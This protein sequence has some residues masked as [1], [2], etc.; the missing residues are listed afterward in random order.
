MAD[1]EAKKSCPQCGGEL[2]RGTLK[3]GNQEANIII[4]GKPD[5]FLGVIPYHDRA[6]DR[7]RLRFLR[8]Y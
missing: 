6:G 2:T 5:G 7:P 3:T 4:A 8:A 1:G